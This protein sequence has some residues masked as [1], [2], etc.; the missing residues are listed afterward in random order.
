MLSD[1]EL[2]QR[3]ARDGSEAAFTELVQRHLNMVYGSALRRVGRNAH[4]A[5]DVTQRVFTDLA[6]KAK[7]LVN[8][9]N[10]AGWLYN[11]TRF[12]SAAAVRSER[13]RRNHEER[14][15]A[16]SE[17][18]ESSYLPG[19]QSLEPLLDEI[20]DLLPEHDREVVLLHVVEGLPFAEVGARLSLKA[21]AAR[22]RVNRAL[23]RLRENLARRGITSTAAA[24]MSALS[25]QA[26]SG[27]AA[28]SAAAV[29][30]EALRMAAATSLDRSDLTAL[31]REGRK[32]P[33]LRWLGATAVVAVAVLTW[34]SAPV[35]PSPP[36]APT[37]V[38][39]QPPIVAEV[40]G[41]TAELQDVEA[42]AAPRAPVSKPISE[43]SALSP[44]ARS[45]LKTLWMHQQDFGDPPVGKKWSVSFGP[46]T[47]MHALF[48]EGRD[49]LAAAGLGRVTTKGGIFITPAGLALATEHRAELDDYPDAFGFRPHPPMVPF[50]ALLEA[51]KSILKRLWSHE[52]QAGTA[53]GTRWS[54]GLTETAP[55]YAAYAEGRA[56]LI[57]R[58]WVNSRPGANT[59]FLTLAGKAYC[60]AHAAELDAS[61][62]L[63][64]Q[65]RPVQ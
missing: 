19:T 17:S 16:M 2:L 52:Q 5:D 61:P 51:E 25:A 7:T 13:R 29:A 10:L 27:P 64:G 54:F 4:A 43:F 58:G 62:Q 37:T 49:I 45:V 20:V 38:L 8:R 15:H 39:A 41:P 23:E 55:R 56:G 1:N 28:P 35:A 18:L 21:D 22:M 31:L 42:V 26:F 3:Y 46:A 30:A 63:F 9:P 33:A 36:A 32:S 44:A 48:V 50:T 59:V 65:S 60:E 12:A 24:L 34:P 6:R 53:P 40:F 47:P 14:A 57:A 11:G